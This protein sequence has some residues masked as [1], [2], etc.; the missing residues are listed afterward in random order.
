[1]RSLPHTPCIDVC[2][3]R[4]PAP[5]CFL[6][7]KIKGMLFKRR[8]Y[9]ADNVTK[10]RHVLSHRNVTPVGSPRVTFADVGDV[11]ADLNEWVVI[12]FIVVPHGSFEL[13]NSDPGIR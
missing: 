13:D 4:N 12:R 8:R 10:E 2:T 7:L 9:V 1:M 6:K 5:W 3:R 11:L